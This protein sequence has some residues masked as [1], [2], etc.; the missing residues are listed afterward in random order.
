[1]RFLRHAKTIVLLSIEDFHREIIAPSDG[2]SGPASLEVRDHLRRKAVE[3][4]V[5]VGDARE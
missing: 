4:G 5:I 1:M 3:H 2:M